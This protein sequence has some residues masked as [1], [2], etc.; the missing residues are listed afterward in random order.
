MTET[1]LRRDRRHSLRWRGAAQFLAAEP[2]IVL[3]VF[4][5]ALMAILNPYFLTVHNFLNVLRQASII[6][7]LTCGVSWMLI[8]G[9]FDLSVGS[10]VSLCSVVMI[11]LLAQGVGV[12]QVL[13]IGV[14]VGV[15]AGLT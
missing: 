4:L 13:V 12:A 9:S 15:V 14:G 8:S 11:G 6:G 10:I 1:I 5:I 3:T 7:I 2:T